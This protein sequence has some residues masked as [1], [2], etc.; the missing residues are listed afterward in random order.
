MGTAIIAKNSDAENSGMRKFIP[1]VTRNL[2]AWHFLNTSVSKAAINYAVGKP[3]AAVVGA[4][5]EFADYI[6]FKGLSNY[7]QTQT[8]DYETQ[9]IFS[10]IRTKDTLVDISHSPSFYGNYSSEGVGCYL[11]W[12]VASAS[13]FKT[14]ARYTDAAKT[15]VSSSPTSLL[16]TMINMGAWSLVID[17]TKAGFN[18]VMNATTNSERTRTDT[19]FGRALSAKTFR[20]GSLYPGASQWTGTADMA[21][22]AHYSTELADSEIAAIVARIRA[23]M[24]RRR[25]ILA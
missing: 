1:P 2:E 15:V 23:Y 17:R 24:S 11:A 10:V 13:L 21:L 14:A 3:D 25:G 7:L 5:S 19:T 12:D 18:G 6:Q 22:W 9:T 4:P 20:I 16:S 8:A